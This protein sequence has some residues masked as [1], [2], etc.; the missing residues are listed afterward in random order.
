MQGWVGAPSWVEMKK[1]AG[2]EIRIMHVTLMGLIVGRARR[3]ER[4]LRAAG[5][6]SWFGSNGLRRILSLFGAYKLQS[7]WPAATHSTHPPFTFFSQSS[8]LPYHPLLLLTVPPGRH[9]NNYFSF[10]GLSALHPYRFPCAFGKK[11]GP[12]VYFTGI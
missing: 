7:L 5:I 11:S 8:Y 2:A 9:S 6:R 1:A 12:G 3:V 4:Y 10:S